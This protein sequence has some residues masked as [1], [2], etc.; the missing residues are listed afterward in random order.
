MGKRKAEVA[1]AADVETG[2]ATKEARTASTAAPEAET[3]RPSRWKRQR[4]RRRR[5]TRT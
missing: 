2:G 5:I 1:S 3:Q 4:P